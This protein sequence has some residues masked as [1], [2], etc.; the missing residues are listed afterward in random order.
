MKHSLRRR[1]LYRIGKSTRAYDSREKR[2]FVLKR[3]AVSKEQLLVC[4]IE[5][6]EEQLSWEIKHFVDLAKANGGRGDNSL[7][8]EAISVV[9]FPVDNETI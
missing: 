5:G 8:P 2:M 9:G 3:G 4:S 1:W 6:V 7:L